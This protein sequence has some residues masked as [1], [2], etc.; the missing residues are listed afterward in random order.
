MPS[1]AVLAKKALVE[2]LDRLT[3]RLAGA[4]VNNL[5]NLPSWEEWN[6]VKR[7]AHVAL[8][9]KGHEPESP[10]FLRWKDLAK[11]E[12]AYRGSSLKFEK[13]YDPILNVLDE[14]NEPFA[15]LQ[16][17]NWEELKRNES[18]RWGNRSRR[19]RVV[20]WLMNRAVNCP[21]FDVRNGYDQVFPAFSDLL[22]VNNQSELSRYDFDKCSLEDWSEVGAVLAPLLNKGWDASIRLKPGETQ[23]TAELGYQY[24]C[25]F[26][27]RRRT[28]VRKDKDAIRRYEWAVNELYEL[29]WTRIDVRVSKLWYQP[30]GKANYKDAVS[31]ERQIR[32]GQTPTLAGIKAGQKLAADR[33][34]KQ[35][36]KPRKF[37]TPVSPRILDMIYSNDFLGTPAWQPVDTEPANTTPTES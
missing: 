9:E 3:G 12:Q 31:P 36:K 34:R 37:I 30:C 1:A 35:P 22:R 27:E 14:S 21:A 18:I 24:F 25:Q 13:W 6:E 4:G 11:L 8:K 33:K 5:L 15:Q 28:W 23:V 19:A 17:T 26:L 10:G 32:N 2:Y 7:L 16:K 20:S 29:Q